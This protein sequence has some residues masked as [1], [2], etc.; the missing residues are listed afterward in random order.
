MIYDLPWYT[1]ILNF[2]NSIDTEHLQ[3]GLGK[4]GLIV[5]VE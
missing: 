1:I 2:I 3:T 4:L 5:A